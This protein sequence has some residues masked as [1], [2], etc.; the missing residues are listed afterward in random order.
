[1]YEHVR[2][3]Q[4]RKTEL[5][6]TQ[7]ELGALIADETGVGE[8]KE[9]FDRRSGQE[10]LERKRKDDFGFKPVAKIFQEFCA[11]HEVDL[12]KVDFDTRCGQQ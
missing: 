2:I 5:P 7:T 1:M 9:R 4:E 11:M 10:S 6:V 3:W 12:D 8:L